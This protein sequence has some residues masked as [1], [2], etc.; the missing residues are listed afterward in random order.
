MNSI[1]LQNSDATEASL[2]IAANG[3]SADFC[4]T[5]NFCIDLLEQLIFSYLLTAI[6]GAL[7]GAGIV[8]IWRQI[9]RNR[10]ASGR[11]GRDAT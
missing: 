2:S 3:N 4:F 6:L 9:G 1:Q 5:A 8:L 11:W 7:I 10:L